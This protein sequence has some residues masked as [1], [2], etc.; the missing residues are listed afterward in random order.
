MQLSEKQRKALRLIGAEIGLEDLEAFIVRE[1]MERTALLEAAG[2]SYKSYPG[3]PKSKT[4][5]RRRN[6]GTKFG[7]LWS[8]PG[9]AYHDAMRRVTG[10]RRR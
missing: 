2:A 8:A 1:G 4:K 7:A 6:S 3:K 10:R 5:T 9:G